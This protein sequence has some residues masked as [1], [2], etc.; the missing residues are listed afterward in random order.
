MSATFELRMSGTFSLNDRPSTVTRCGRRSRD[1]PPQTFVRDAAA[2]CFVDAPA[3]Q[4]DLG[5]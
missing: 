5:W 2:H 4:D 3:G 1:Q